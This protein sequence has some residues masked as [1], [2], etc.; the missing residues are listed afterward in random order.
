MALDQENQGLFG[1]LQQVSIEKAHQYD[2][3]STHVLQLE[4]TLRSLHQQAS[5]QQTSPKEP[6]ICLPGKFDG[7][8][9]Q[10][11]GFLIQVRLE[12]QMHP[13]RYPTDAT[14]V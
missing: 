4:A 1:D 10:F 7:N 3:L 14:Q 9:S 11:R 6:K 5:M 8:R 2:E 13:N 12:I